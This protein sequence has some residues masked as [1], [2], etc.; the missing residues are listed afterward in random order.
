MAEFVRG[1]QA[2]LAGEIA[3][4]EAR[5]AQ[6]KQNLEQAVAQQAGNSANLDD[7]KKLYAQ[8]TWYICCLQTGPAESPGSQAAM[9]NWESI[10]DKAQDSCDEGLM[11]LG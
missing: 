2:K 8:V 5:Q 1:R 11:L 6:F 4:L 9:M 7:A 10:V 3:N